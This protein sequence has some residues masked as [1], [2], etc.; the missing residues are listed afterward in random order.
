MTLCCNRFQRSWLVNGKKR[1]CGCA[2]VDIDKLELN[3]IFRL[4]VSVS[5][6]VRVRV[7]VRF[8]VSISIYLID[9]IKLQ[10]GSV[11]T[12]NIRRSA[13]PQSAFYPW[14]FESTAMISLDQ[15]CI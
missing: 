14:P 6:R 5:V 2:D 10:I 1:I 3:F 7:G 15:S 11:L 9:V 12:N 13:N 8:R 4:R